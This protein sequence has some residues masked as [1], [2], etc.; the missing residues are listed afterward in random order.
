[1]VWLGLTALKSLNFT[2]VANGRIETGDF[3]LCAAFYRRAYQAQRVHGA[4]VTGLLAVVFVVVVGCCG[5]DWFKWWWFVVVGGGLL[6]LVVVAASFAQVRRNIF[7]FLA[8]GRRLYLTK[9]FLFFTKGNGG[10]CAKPTHEP[11]ICRDFGDGC[12]LY[13]EWCCCRDWCY[14][15]VILFL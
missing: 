9:L 6:L 10:M 13:I 5:I 15:W 2:G 14:D 8:E 11:S 1:M 7:D 12:E 4:D 3:S